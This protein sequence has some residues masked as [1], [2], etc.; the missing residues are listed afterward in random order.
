MLVNT[1]AV[2]P[3]SRVLGGGSPPELPGS[4]IPLMASFSGA[5]GISEKSLVS[6]GQ[7]VW[8]SAVIDGKAV[9]P[10][11]ERWEVDFANFAVDA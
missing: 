10:L 2:L 3:I 1:G 11:R 5:L 4:Q 8:S 9:L 6:L 7:Q